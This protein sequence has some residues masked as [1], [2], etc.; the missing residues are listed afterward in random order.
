MPAPLRWCKLWF[1]ILEDSRTC[2]LPPDHFKAWIACLILAGENR[3][4]GWFEPRLF[5][6]RL[7]LADPGPTL[8][9]LVDRGL[10]TMTADPP[11]ITV[12]QWK[13]RQGGVARSAAFRN[14]FSVG[15]TDVKRRRDGSATPVSRKRERERERKIVQQEVLPSSQPAAATRREPSQEARDVACYLE[16]AIL[17]HSPTVKTRPD[18]WAREIDLA[19]RVDGRTPEQLRRVVDCAHRSTTDTFWRSNLLSGMKLREKFDVLWVRANAG[20]KPAASGYRGVGPREIMEMAR[21]SRAQEEAAGDQDGRTGDRG[22]AEGAVS[23]R[24]LPIGDG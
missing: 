15:V 24:K 10:V 3:M 4:C 1:D 2:D 8:A 13:S 11:R 18:L 16:Q 9:A 17:S 5:A 19:I 22:N 23:Q 14:G 7:R 20:A 21:Q 12:V 6:W